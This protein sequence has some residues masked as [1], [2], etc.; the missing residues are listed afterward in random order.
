MIPS[1]S[2]VFT[3]PRQ[4]PSR[5]A[6]VLSCGTYIYLIISLMSK[7]NTCGK[8]GFQRL[9]HIDVSIFYN[10]IKAVELLKRFVFLKIWTQ[11]P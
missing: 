3:Q 9:N 4:R 2:L 5:L 11:F 1:Y 10:N 6:N 7:F 8:D